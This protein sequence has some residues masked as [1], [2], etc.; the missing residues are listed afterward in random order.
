MDALLQSCRRWSP[1][2]S[3]GYESLTEIKK[4]QQEVQEASNHC[5]S[6]PKKIA[7]GIAPLGLISIG[8]VPMGVI[9]I[10]VVPMGVISLGVV[11]MGV[12]NASVVG[13]GVISAGLTTMGVWEWS[14]SGKS[15]EHHGRI[16]NADIHSTHG[17]L[18][19]HFAYP[20]RS[21]A[22][23]QA[24]KMGCSGVHRMGQLWMPC[25][26]QEIED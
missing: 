6:N 17:S 22:E 5:G 15:H 24:K 14:P 21:E 25:D 19:N 8:I 11:A 7:F 23:A 4:S 2:S 12:V 16:H 13:M 3:W 26:M 10:G 1:T 9:T 18:K 20:S